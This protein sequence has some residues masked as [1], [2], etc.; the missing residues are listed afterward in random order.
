M[1]R[2]P[3][4]NFLHY[5][6]NLGAND[7]IDS[8]GYVVRNGEIVY[9]I[10]GLATV[11]SIYLANIHS[12]PKTIAYYLKNEKR[13]RLNVFESLLFYN[14]STDPR[15]DLDNSYFERFHQIAVPTFYLQEKLKTSGYKLLVRPAALLAYLPSSD[16]SLA[17]PKPLSDYVVQRYGV[18]LCD[19]PH[20]LFSLWAATN[21]T[22]NEFIWEH[23]FVNIHSWKSTVLKRFLERNALSIE[24]YKEVFANSA[25]SSYNIQANIPVLFANPILRVGEG[26]YSI[27]IPKLLFLY[28]EEH[29]YWDCFDYFKKINNQADNDFTRWYGKVFE[30]YCWQIL[31]SVS[32]GAISD[33]R[34]LEKDSI[35]GPDC[36]EITSSSTTF[37]EFKVRRPK[38]EDLISWGKDSKESLKKYLRDDHVDQFLRFSAKYKS[39]GQSHP[40]FPE[41]SKTRRVQFV[42]ITPISIY[43]NTYIQKEKWFETELAEIGRNLGLK[44]PVQLIYGSVEDLESISKKGAGVYPG[45]M[46][47]QYVSSADFFPMLS[48]NEWHLSHGKRDGENPYLGKTIEQIFGDTMRDLNFKRKT[49]SL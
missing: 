49:A 13:D 36:A 25:V 24:G 14:S 38:R 29:F 31:K 47:K 42:V 33:L 27:P 11:I 4:V 20:C 40:L 17:P 15:K 22:G 16:E 48:F 26:V 45:I 43:V 23:T 28:F 10:H 34:S 30:E 8:K 5:V 32:N 19:L 1:N 41:L 12:S 35:P 44:K 3:V 18:E 39:L 37:F 21:S 6:S 7:E 9:S 2:I 46:W